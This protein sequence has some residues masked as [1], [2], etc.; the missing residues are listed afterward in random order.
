[1]V[2]IIIVFSH[3][4]RDQFPS[5]LARGHNNRLET[6]RKKKNGGENERGPL[7]AKQRYPLEEKER[8]PLEE[9]QNTI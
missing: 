3:Y 1:M 2:I 5:N 7:E 4:L 8:D 9:T 6:R